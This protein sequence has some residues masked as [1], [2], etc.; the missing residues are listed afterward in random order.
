MITQSVTTERQA[1]FLNEKQAIRLL[2]SYA[3]ERR[4][5][6]LAYPN[7]KGVAEKLTAVDEILAM[8][9]EAL[10]LM[11]RAACA[12]VLKT[13]LN[14]GYISPTATKKIYTSYTAKV[15]AIL[16]ACRGY[17]GLIKQ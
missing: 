8:L 16:S 3:L 2:Q 6:L 12:K 17:L 5:A 11:P 4:T 9:D 10:K 7:A 15:E 14:F 1:I 13:A